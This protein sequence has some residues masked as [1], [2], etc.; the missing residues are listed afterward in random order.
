[1]QIKEYT[2]RECGKSRNKRRREIEREC[3]CMCVCICVWRYAPWLPITHFHVSHSLVLVTEM[4]ARYIRGA[5]VGSAESSVQT[6]SE[7]NEGGRGGDMKKER[8]SFADREWVREGG[9]GLWKM[10]VALMFADRHL[11]RYLTATARAN[12]WQ[13]TLSTCGRVWERTSTYTTET[14]TY[15]YVPSP[16]DRTRRVELH[17]AAPLAL[18]YSTA[19]IDTRHDS[20]DPPWNTPSSPRPSIS[21]RR[22]SLQTA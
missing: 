11:A 5:V 15:T 17:A 13:C 20:A 7:I 16:E 21:R 2:G 1:M 10:S 14:H 18:S 9:G 19:R 6:R 3:V 22:Y 4:N 12:E 8:T